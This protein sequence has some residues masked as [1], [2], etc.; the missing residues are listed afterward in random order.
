MKLGVGTSRTGK[1]PLLLPS[2]LLLSSLLWCETIAYRNAPTKD[3]SEKLVAAINDLGRSLGKQLDSNGDD[4]TKAEIFSPVSIGTM[5]FLLLRIANGSLRNELLAMLGLNGVEHITKNFGHLLEELTSDIAS[6]GILDELPGWHTKQS[7]YPPEYADEYEDYIDESNLSEPVDPNIIRIANGMFVQDGLIHN[8]TD[9]VELARQLYKARIARVDF[10]QQPENARN[11]INQWVDSSTNGRIKEILPASLPRTTQL[12]LAS[13]LYFKASWETFF[14]DP[15]YTRNQPFFPDGEDKPA[16]DVPTMFTGGCFPYFAS[17]EH[18]ASIMAFPYR[19]RTTSMYIILPNA[20]NREKVRA[21]RAKLGAAEL[22]QLIGQMVRR[23]A[24]V[25]F[26]RMH[27][28]SHYNLR[29]SL[30]QLGVKSLFDPT[31]RNFKI[32]Q[33]PKVKGKPRDQDAVKKSPKLYVDSMVHQ[34]DLE[35]NEHGTEGGA[36][37]MAVMDRSAPPVT[38]RVRG[39][40]LIAIRHDPTKMLLFYGA[41]YDPS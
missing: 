14:N 11:S 28:N 29:D 10:R 8:N 13:A 3:V 33:S 4:S 24:M 23:K 38:F 39:P 36:V 40:F 9:M 32:E 2:L 17:S 37:T 31:K 34:V 18:D 7:C 6:N 27:V 22:D 5:M 16:V 30:E 41:V 21:L 12:V 19:N 1:I 35:V 25:V 26:P 15:Q 20:S